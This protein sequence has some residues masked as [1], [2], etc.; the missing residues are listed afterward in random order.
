MIT[1]F[2]QQVLIIASL[3]NFMIGETL[4]LWVAAFV[5]SLKNYVT[6]DAV[7]ILFAMS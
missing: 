6:D 5:I 3:E 1:Y 7:S 4:F 2:Y